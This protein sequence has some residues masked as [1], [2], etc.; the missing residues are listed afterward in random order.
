METC[1]TKYVRGNEREKAFKGE[2][3]EARPRNTEAHYMCMC[4]VSSR[5][6]NYLGWPVY[7]I[8]E[9]LGTRC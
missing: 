8:T 2:G 4:V 9:Q 7:D 1:T 5:S 6:D 3:P